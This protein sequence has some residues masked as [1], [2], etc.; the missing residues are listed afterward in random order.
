M[1][2][3]IV[4]LCCLVASLVALPAIAGPVPDSPP[5][6]SSA[7]ILISAKTGRVLAAEDA[8][9]R[10]APASLT[11][12]MTAYVVYKALDSGGI[13]L[14]DEVRISKAV[15]K[16]HG[17]QMF[18]EVGATPTVEQLLHGLI[19]QSGNDAALAL[20]EYVGGSAAAFVQMMNYY[21]DQ[22]GMTNTHFANP[23][24]LDA[25]NHYSTAR[26]LAT[27]ARAVIRQYPEHY[28]RYSIKSYTY[29]NIQ[30][31]NRNR[32]LWTDPSVDG[33][34]TGHTS[35]AGYC[36]IASAERDGMR[37]ISVVLNAPTEDQRF[38]DT[39][40]LFAW[41]YRFFETHRLYAAGETLEEARIWQGAVDRIALGLQH[42][43][44]VTIPDGQYDAL[45][46]QISYPGQLVAPIKA[47][48]RLG[49]VEVVLEDQ[50][51]AKK[52]LVALESVKEG[53]FFQ[54]MADV[55]LQ[56]FQ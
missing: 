35:D 48:E 12:V 40:A 27:L 53:S 2:R 38:S 15:W 5:L 42:G 47:G 24:G 34:K 13:A 6:A 55:V 37:L 18:L 3:S 1:K 17:S 9:K 26:D 21:A 31:Y 29:N 20:A 25:E 54:R 45:N 56:W 50:T 49:T 52:P 16:M 19:V 8:D 43:L 22:L 4:S 46:A 51:I 11:K 32:L 36:L 28:K 39:R 33:M 14:S 7:H 10:L 30:Q 41:G 44:L 23:T